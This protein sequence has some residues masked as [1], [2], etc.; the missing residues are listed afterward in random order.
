MKVG[1]LFKML[2]NIRNVSEDMIDE[3][4]IDKFRLKQIF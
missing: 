3:E 2:K 1:Q 4:L